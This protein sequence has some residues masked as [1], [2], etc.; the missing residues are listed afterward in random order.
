VAAGHIT[1]C[2]MASHAHAAAPPA[3]PPAA[4]PSPAAPAPPATAVRRTDAM[5]PEPTP[6]SRP[7]ASAPHATPVAPAQGGSGLG[8]QQHGPGSAE[9]PMPAAPEE[10]AQVRRWGAAG[11]DREPGVPGECAGVA[12]V[13]G[14][15]VD[16][17][18]GSMRKPPPHPTPH[19]SQVF[20]SHEEWFSRPLPSA[21]RCTACCRRVRRWGVTADCRPQKTGRTDV[22]PR[23]PI[24]EP[25]QSEAMGTSCC[26]MAEAESRSN[27]CARGPG[28]REEIARQAHPPTHLHPP[29]SDGSMLGRV[30]ELEALISEERAKLAGAPPPPTTTTPYQNG[31][32]IHLWMERPHN[33]HLP[34]APSFSAAVSSRRRRRSGRVSAAAVCRGR[35]CAG[36]NWRGASALSNAHP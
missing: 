29:S 26:A 12:R 20:A 31:S 24:V 27:R 7:H 36:R 35:G 25:V 4:T 32:L 16:L 14:D 2:I 22:P 18:S 9:P 34:P 17:E 30:S 28:G 6:Q 1:L 10:Y 11:G 13:Q 5:F 8:R 15:R 3:A 21:R 23:P 19:P 33:A